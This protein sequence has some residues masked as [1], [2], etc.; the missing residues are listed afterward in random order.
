M[1]PEEARQLQEVHQAVLGVPHTDN[2]GLCGEIKA[3]KLQLG[4]LNG[5]VTRNTVFRK[6]G[7]WL[8]GAITITLIGLLA[9][10]L[11]E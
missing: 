7:T 5:Q 2:K 3:I 11:G 9:K 4:D 10:L 6:I 8:S 1:N